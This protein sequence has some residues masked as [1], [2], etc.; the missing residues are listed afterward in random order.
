MTEKQAK[1]I[2]EKYNPAGAITRCPNGRALVRTLLNKYARAAVNLYG[3]I[4]RAELAEIF[5]SQNMEK[6]NADE[7]F[8]LLLPLVLKAKWYCFYKDYIVHYWAMED[9]DCAEYWLREQGDKPRYVPDKD[10]FLKY[11][12]QYYESDA[13]K[14][15][16]DK[17]SGF[18]GKEWPENNQRYS[19]YH[20]LKEITEFDAGIQEII[21]LLD[22][23]EL[24]FT[25]EKQAQA[26]FDLLMDAGNNTRRWVHKGCSPK[27][28]RENIERQR[29]KAGSS[30]IVIRE[31]KKVGPNEF[32]PCGS[33]KKYKKCCRLT[34]EAQTA[35]LTRSECMLFYETWYGLMG[36]INKREKVIEAVIKPVWPNPVSDEQVYKIRE[37]LWEN[38]AWIDDYLAAAVLPD[39]TRELLKSWRDHHKKGMFFVVDYSPE[40]AIV[41]GSNEQKEGRLYGIKGISR[42]LADAMRRELPIQFESV[43][44]PFQGKIIYDSFMSTM[45]IEF[46]EGA[47]RAFREMYD[48]AL[49]HGIVSSLE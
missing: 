20:E 31:R 40:Y 47:K 25:G 28:L 5:V 46:G 10:E 6:T 15:Y 3:I 42:S 24:G 16:W 41:I 44:L 38:P 12:N 8:I 36:H 7:V 14:S 33:G 4:S 1:T 37:V 49:V 29:Q 9:F 19:F 48:N 22:K 23:Y 13:Q 39:E 43:L 11:E 18:I 21:G 32:C 34:E 35:Q 27:E 2:F 30:E 26:F 17:L 45:P